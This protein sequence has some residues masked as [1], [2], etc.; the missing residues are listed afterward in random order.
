[1]SSRQPGQGPPLRLG[2]RIDAAD[3][4]V[5]AEDP[6]L[7]LPALVVPAVASAHDVQLL[8]VQLGRGQH[9]LR[10]DPFIVGAIHQAGGV[11]GPADGVGGQQGFEAIAGDA[12]RTHGALDL[13]LVDRI[14]TQ[15]FEAPALFQAIRD[16][17]KTAIASLAQRQ[18][19]AQPDDARWRSRLREF[20]QNRF[21]PT[22]D[23]GPRPGAPGCRVPPA[24]LAEFGFSPTPANDTPKPDLFA[25]GAAA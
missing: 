2:R 20:R 12:R 1:M 8:R 22:D 3:H 10:V 17:P 11:L 18:A 9:L 15:G 24:I 5:D 13:G 25:E 16:A 23:A 4:E 14:A 21:W 7:D 6:L 19:H